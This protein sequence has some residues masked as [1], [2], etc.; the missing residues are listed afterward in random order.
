LTAN[1][2]PAFVALPALLSL[3]AALFR[4]SSPPSWLRPIVGIDGRQENPAR[5]IS[6]PPADLSRKAHVALDSDGH[7]FPDAQTFGQLEPDPAIR[8][9]EDGDIAYVPRGND[10]DRRT[11]EVDPRRALAESLDAGD[12]PP[13][14]PDRLLT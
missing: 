4:H 3:I 1:L 8:D 13:P 12:R 14:A 11:P 6:K 10:E 9:V 2:L 7:E 5:L